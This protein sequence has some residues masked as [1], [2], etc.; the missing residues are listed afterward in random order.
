MV[1]E[2]SGSLLGA[3]TQGNEGSKETTI[4]SLTLPD[5]A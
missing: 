1:T 2:W 5:V 4:G 3:E